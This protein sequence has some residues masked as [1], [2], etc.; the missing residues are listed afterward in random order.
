VTVNLL[1]FEQLST[2]LVDSVSLRPL[3]LAHG[4]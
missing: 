2:A 4:G 3:P 1:Q